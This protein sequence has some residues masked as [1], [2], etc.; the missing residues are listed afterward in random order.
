[1][2][3]PLS[4]LSDRHPEAGLLSHVAILHSGFGGAAVL[5]SPVA[6]GS[7][8]LDSCASRAG[9]CSLSGISPEAGSR[10]P[11]SPFLLRLPVSQIFRCVNGWVADES[12]FRD[13]KQ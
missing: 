3:T 13:L 2:E 7:S 5:S 9:V 12:D 1:M 10:G 11:L 8:L 4:V 6:E